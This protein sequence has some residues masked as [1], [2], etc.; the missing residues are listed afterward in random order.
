MHRYNFVLTILA[1]FPLPA[2]LSLLAEPFLAPHDPF[3]RHEIR[4]LQDYGVL[5]ST[6][7]SWPLNLGGMSYEKSN[8]NLMV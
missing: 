1:F 7:N 4:I 2:G 6:L 8:N 3:L 5:N